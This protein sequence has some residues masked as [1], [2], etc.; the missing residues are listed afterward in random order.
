VTEYQDRTERE[1]AEV[2]KSTEKILLRSDEMARQFEKLL[3][4]SE[5]LLERLKE[6][7]A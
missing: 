1:A 2:V 3:R 6:R 4:E 5:R 7:G